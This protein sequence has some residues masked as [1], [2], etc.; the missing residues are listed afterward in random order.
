MKQGRRAAH[1]C[2]SPTIQGVQYAATI[3]VDCL[4]RHGH[5]I[6]MAAFGKPEENGYAE[7]LRRTVKEE[8]VNLSD[9]A[10][11]QDAYRQLGRFLDDVYSHKRIHSA[12]G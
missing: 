3:Y 1:R 8:E 5:S 2:P 12:L 4:Q 7:R 11:F 6:S 9:Y 10:D